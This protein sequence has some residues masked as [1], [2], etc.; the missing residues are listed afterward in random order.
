MECW[1]DTIPCWELEMEGD[2]SYLPLDGKGTDIAGT[3]LP[4]GQAETQIPGGEPDFISRMIDRGGRPAGICIGL[5]SP[6]CMLEL[7]MR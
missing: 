6:H 5:V 2:L 1:M 4:A 7:D 3:Q